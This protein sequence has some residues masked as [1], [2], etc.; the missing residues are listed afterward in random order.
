MENATSRIGD[1]Q[2]DYLSGKDWQKRPAVE[3]TGFG[4]GTYAG[5]VT[6]AAVIKAGLGIALLATPLTG[7]LLLILPSQLVLL[8]LKLVIVLDS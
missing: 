6:G 4:L 7:Y 2:V 1:V 3:A 8:L 5:L